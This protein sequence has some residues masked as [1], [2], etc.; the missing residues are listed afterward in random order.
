MVMGDLL[1]ATRSTDIG[2]KSFTSNPAA[3]NP[4]ID[5]KQDYAPESAKALIEVG[6]MTGHLR[7]NRRKSAADTET[8][9]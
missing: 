5:H 8:S 4:S 1:A 7:P 2:I 9:S 3:R 6:G